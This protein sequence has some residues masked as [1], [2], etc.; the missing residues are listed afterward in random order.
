MLA[1]S[2]PL[3]ELAEFSCTWKTLCAANLY[4]LSVLGEYSHS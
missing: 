2:Y 4:L 3:Q 1:R